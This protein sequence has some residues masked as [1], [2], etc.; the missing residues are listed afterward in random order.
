MKKNKQEKKSKKPE[1]KKLAGRPEILDDKLIKKVE[2]YLLNG[3]YAEM[4]ASLAHISKKTF[5]SWLRLG[6]KKDSPE[7]YKRFLHAIEHGVNKGQFLLL[8]RIQTRAKEDWKAAAW[9]LERRN[10]KH[11]SPRYLVTHQGDEENPI[12]YKEKQENKLKEKIIK[13]RE[14]REAAEKL[15]MASLEFSE[16]DENEI[17]QHEEI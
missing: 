7:I 10:Q 12:V 17:E 4:A 16:D 6:H 1:E 13:D 15:A 2:G 5:Y 14:L 8:S 9:I 11:W 3:C